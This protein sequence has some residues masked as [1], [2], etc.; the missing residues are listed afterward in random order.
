M[1]ETA[2]VLKDLAQPWHLQI[3][4]SP[5]LAARVEKASARIDRARA[6]KDLE[7]LQR[8]RE[9]LPVR[10]AATLVTVTPW[11]ILHN[12]ARGTVLARQ[13][14]GR[15][16]GE[17]WGCLK[18]C[19]ALGND[20]GFLTLSEEGQDPKRHYRAVQS[21]EL[22]V[23]F[24][25]AVVKR[26]LAERYPDHAI[27]VV[28]ADVALQAGWALTA[29][30]A[31]QKAK[32][33]QGIWTRHRP[34]FFVELWKAG[35][36]SRVV[37]I[38]CKGNHS[39]RSTVSNQLS[40]ASSHLESVQIG[41]WNAVSG[42]VTSVELLSKAGLV[43]HILEAPGD[44]TLYGTRP[45]TN[46]RSSPEQQNLPTGTRVSRGPDDPPA[47]LSGYQVKPDEYDWFRDVLARTDAAALMAFAGV[48]ASTA[49]Y[50]TERQGKA[51]FE[52]Y[53]HAG[54]G[55]V[56]DIDHTIH[57]IKFLGTD[58]VFRLNRRRVEAFS[59][60]AE[61]LFEHL[62]ARRVREYRDALPAW[63]AKRPTSPEAPEWDGPVSIH[64]DGSVLGIRLLP[65]RSLR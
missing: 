13:G 61:D 64:P 11:D 50:L 19:Q 65:E 21:G 20:G 3:Q 37:L 25:L 6:K 46:L 24:T 26:V 39:R 40:T 56:R 42:L 28:D 17:H 34:H 62:A 2:D 30:Q 33:V 57:G 58:H 16:V 49:Q 31:R 41:P 1:K 12:L 38:A 32:D 22:S 52:R 7:P 51:H 54:T 43:L 9:L 4:S 8:K 10:E 44:G 48:G 23:G 60:F 18:Y 47:S 45:I 14:A 35:E 15:G 29:A 53:T 36:P 55:V 59:G 63:N 27:S 5:P